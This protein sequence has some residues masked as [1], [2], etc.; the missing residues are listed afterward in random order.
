MKDLYK[1]Y[2]ALLELGLEPE[3]MDKVCADMD[4]AED[5]ADQIREAVGIIKLNS[6]TQSN[7][8]QSKD[9]L[10]FSS[11]IIGRLPKLD[12]PHFSGD[13]SQWVAFIHLFDSLVHSRGDL[14]SAQKLAYLLASLTGE[15]KGLVQHLALVDNNY[16]IARD[17]L[18]RRYQNIRR[19]ADSH[20][21]VILNLHSNVQSHNLR[22]QVLNPLLVA[23]NGLRGLNLPVDSWSFI[24][25]HI[26]L[27]KL[28]LDMRTRFEQA[29]GGDSTTHLPT[30][31]ELILF[32]EDECRRQ[33]N[34]PAPST[35]PAPISTRPRQQHMRLMR[36]PDQRVYNVATQHSGKC[37]VYCRV[38][39]HT[40]VSCQKFLALRF[41]AR[42]NIARQRKW[43]YGC[44][45]KHL[46]SQCQVSRPCKQCN[47]NHHIILCGNMNGSPQ[48]AAPAREFVEDMQ[49][50]GDQWNGGVKVRHC[51]FGHA[52][53]HRTGS[54]YYDYH[55]RQPPPCRGGG[56]LRSHDRTRVTSDQ[57]QL[58]KSKDNYDSCA[59][60]A[61][62]QQRR[63]FVRPL[64]FSEWPR[65]GQRVP[66]PEG[67]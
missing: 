36:R 13:L 56:N 30:F 45:G 22:I 44:L 59:L 65:L 57:Q 10:T 51:S 24:L 37:C 34:V 54:G 62:E 5:L 48:S 47:G 6:A 12:L 61:I 40:V 7:N 18:M 2:Q 29:Y 60:P 9:S 31:D 32:L 33:D 11:G 52:S 38:P 19:L 28:N 15:A 27:Q 3:V 26:T 67:Y 21:N 4:Q 63:D 41:Q 1:S 35:T 17:L 16:D 66:E 14:T 43:C 58:P 50:T 49:N 46:A 55:R 39:D 53:R 20:V 64:P 25:L 23:I 42:R 8:L